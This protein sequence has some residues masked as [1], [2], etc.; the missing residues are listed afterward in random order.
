MSF[1]SKLKPL[2]LKNGFMCNVYSLLTIYCLISVVQ[3]LT[4]GFIAV[5]FIFSDL[6]ILVSVWFSN[7]T[8]HAISVLRFLTTV[9]RM[10]GK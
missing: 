5:V 3:V 10:K 6:Y 2:G 1:F 4:F 8:H 7:V 9:Q